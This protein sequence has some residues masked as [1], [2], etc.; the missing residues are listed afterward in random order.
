MKQYCN[1]CVYSGFFLFLLLFA[2]SIC[3]QTI[4]DPAPKKKDPPPPRNLKLISETPDG[5]GNIV[6]VI[7][8]DQ[9]M[10]RVTE[11]IIAPKALPI[12][13][14]SIRISPDTMNK[15]SVKLVVDKTKRCLLVLYRKRVIRAYKATFG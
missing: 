11:T 1:R 12:G 7:Q 14:T 15:D 8:Y 10:M 6:R 4:Y 9:G 3:A 5:K 13:S 2:T